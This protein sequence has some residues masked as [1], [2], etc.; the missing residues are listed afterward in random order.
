VLGGGWDE[1]AGVGGGI[2][3]SDL[4][5]DLATWEVTAHAG[6]GVDQTTATYAI[7]SSIS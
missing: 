3:A 2:F 5:T 4:T 6:Y 7:C 1:T